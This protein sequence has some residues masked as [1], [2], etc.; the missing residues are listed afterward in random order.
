[1]SFSPH[2]QCVL[3]NQGIPLGLLLYTVPNY[4]PWRFHP[5]PLPFLRRTSSFG[6]GRYTSGH[7]C[8]FAL[9][10]SPSSP[11]HT[12]PPWASPLLASVLSAPPGSHCSFLPSIF[13]HG[14]EWLYSTCRI[15]RISQSN[16]TAGAKAPASPHWF[17][18]ST[19]YRFALLFQHIRGNSPGPKPASKSPRTPHVV[20][21]VLNPSHL[22][23]NPRLGPAPETAQIGISTGVSR[24]AP[25]RQPLHAVA[26]W[27]QILNFTL[28]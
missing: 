16:S 27:K 18:T 17:S 21:Y 8:I 4:S 1:M 22:A 6:V 13:G 23:P 25:L 7:P 19:S 12:R 9:P 28:C 20:K 26:G 2:C 3:A 14:T 15:F 11:S 5:L 10:Y 24:S